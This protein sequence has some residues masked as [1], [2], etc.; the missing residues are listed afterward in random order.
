MGRK[1]ACVFYLLLLWYKYL[2][3]SWRAEECPHYLRCVH[4]WTVSSVEMWS[5]SKPGVMVTV[6]QACR[7]S[8]YEDV[9]CERCFR[10]AFR[11][12]SLFLPLQRVSFWLEGHS[13]PDEWVSTWL[14]FLPET[15]EEECFLPVSQICLFL[16]SLTMLTS[17][18][19]ISEISKFLNTILLSFSLSS[20]VKFKDLSFSSWYRYIW[21][22]IFCVFT[23]RFKELIF[24]FFPQYCEQF[25]DW[26]NSVTCDCG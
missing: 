5:W 11:S 4:H 26:Y 12:I 25:I 16:I 20:K 14:I 1:T 8:P 21:S 18:L 9:M 10:E 2:N 19:C 15:L 17:L 23:Y 22:L 3:L 7:L 24:M 6:R 13:C